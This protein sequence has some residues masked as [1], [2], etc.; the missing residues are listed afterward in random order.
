M[1]VGMRAGFIVIVRI[2]FPYSA[3]IFWSLIKEYCKCLWKMQITISFMA[4]KRILLIR[5]NQF[6]FYHKKA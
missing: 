6:L 1:C 5:R 2:T 3:G 4:F